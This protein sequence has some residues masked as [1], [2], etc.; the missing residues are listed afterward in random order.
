MKNERQLTN[1]VLLDDVRQY[2]ENTRCR[3]AKYVDFEI[4]ATLSQKLSWSRF[5]EVMPLKDDIQRE[6]YLT[7]AASEH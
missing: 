3:V 6:F 4:F 5:V 7:M 1:A 2:I